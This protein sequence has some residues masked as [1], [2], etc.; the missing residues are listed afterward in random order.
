MLKNQNTKPLEKQTEIDDPRR[1]G[2]WVLEDGDSSHKTGKID[3]CFY[4]V[5]NSDLET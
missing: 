2:V 1:N 4:F 5:L 3:R